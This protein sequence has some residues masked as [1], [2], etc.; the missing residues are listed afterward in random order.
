MTEYIIIVGL[1][2]IL[3]I[4]AIERFSR[5]LKDAYG[6]STDALARHVTNPIGRMGSG[7][8]SPSV[9]SGGSDDEMASS[10]DDPHPATLAPKKTGQ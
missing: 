4:T 3:A 1:I 10:N 7:G 6:K 5:S 8:G 9:G 2:A